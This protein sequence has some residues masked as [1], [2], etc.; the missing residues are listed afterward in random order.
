MVENLFIFVIKGG[1]VS[2]KLNHL[3]GKRNENECDFESV[4]SLCIVSDV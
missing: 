3:K 1:G 2:D 4:G